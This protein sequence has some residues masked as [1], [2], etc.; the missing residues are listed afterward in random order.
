M[1]AAK[2]R[3]VKGF[4]HFLDLRV[5]EV[6]HY[7]RFAKADSDDQTNDKR[8]S[9]TVNE[10]VV[11][12]SCEDIGLLTCLVSR[13]KV[14]LSLTEDLLRPVELPQLLDRPG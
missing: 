9:L 1:Y 14:D 12:A 2:S 10:E 6:G 3:F 8:Y 5:Y 4:A 7:V 11:Q 13:R